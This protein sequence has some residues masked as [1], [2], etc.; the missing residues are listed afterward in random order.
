MVIPMMP[1][2]LTSPIPK[3]HAAPKEM[4]QN[5]RIKNPSQRH[6]G[7]VSQVVIHPA[8]HAINMAG[9]TIAENPNISTNSPLI[10]APNIPA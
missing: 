9:Q 6:Q 8:P 4:R 3:F 7:I 5:E 10:Y 1:P 2:P